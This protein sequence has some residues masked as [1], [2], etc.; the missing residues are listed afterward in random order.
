[1][2]SLAVQQQTGGV[3]CG[4]FAIAFLEYIA[5]TNLYPTKTWFDQSKFRNHALRCLKDDIIYP[6]PE[7]E[8]NKKR[9]EQFRRK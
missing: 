4:L 1:M 7:T 8:S 3:D 6:F 5:R 2:K 9:Y